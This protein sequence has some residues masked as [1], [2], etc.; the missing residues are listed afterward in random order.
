MSLVSR[1]RQ[2][3][4]YGVRRIFRRRWHAVQM[5]THLSGVHPRTCPVCGYQGKFRAWGY[6]MVLDILCARCDSL[7]RHRLFWLMDQRHGFLR[8]VKSMVHFAPEDILRR[9]FCQ[10]MPDYRAADLF[11]ADVDYHYNIEATGLPAES[12]DA[13]F[14]SHIFEHVDD[15][16]A[17]VE[18]HRILRSGGRLI[19]MVPLIEAWEH[20]YENPAVASDRERDLHFGQYDH[21]RFYGRDFVTRL[22]EA[23]FQVASYMGTPEECVTYGLLRGEKVFVATK[24]GAGAAQVAG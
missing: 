14:A 6:P 4:P 17:M 2:S 23:G 12:I 24:D 5:F 13:V 10:L 3:I 8:D 1:V 20:T 22:Q 15:R 9:K 11:R 7:D 21:V 18:M 16:K 19:A